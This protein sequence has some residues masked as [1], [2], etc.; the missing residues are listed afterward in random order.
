[1]SWPDRLKMARDFCGESQQG[2]AVRLGVPYRTYQG[3]EIGNSEPKSKVLERL[4]E[5]G[6]SSHW[7]LTGTGPL[8]AEE[9][10][11]APAARPSHSAMQLD[12]ELSARVVD[13]ISRLYKAENVGLSAMDL[14]RMAARLYADLVN[15]YDDPAERQVGLK[16]ALEQLRRELRAPV[17]TGSSKRSA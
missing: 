5:L 17:E 1:M 7:V 14:G 11:G 13:G 2:M 4:V 8:R 10:A 6:F 15:A 3:Y 16:L 12:E 9:L